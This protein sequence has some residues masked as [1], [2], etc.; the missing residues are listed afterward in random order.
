MTNS[1]N[2]NRLPQQPSLPQLRKQAKEL[3]RACRSG[4]QSAT[5]R[6]SNQLRQLAKEASRVSLSLAQFTLARE[7]GFESWS[8]L[9]FFIESQ[10]MTFEEKL[11]LFVKAA[12]GNKLYISESLLKKEPKLAIHDLST[13]CIV[14]DFAMVERLIKQNPSLVAE[15]VGVESWTPLLYVCFSFF[16]RK[17]K[18]TAENLLKT[19]QVLISAGADVNATYQHP[20]HDQFRIPCLY[21]PSGA[22]NFPELTELLL[23]A[24]ANPDER[25]S[26]Y[27]ST[28]FRDGRC[29][30]LLLQHGASADSWGA[31]HHILDFDDL[32]GA[33]KLLKAGANPNVGYEDLGTSLHHAIVRGRGRKTIELLLEFGAI[34]DRENARGHTPY[35]LALRYGNLEAIEV[36]RDKSAKR[37]LT[38]ASELIACCAA[39]DRKGAEKVLAKNPDLIRSLSEFDR[40]MVAEFAALGKAEAVLLMIDLGFDINE[41]GEWGGPVIQQAAWNGHV[42][43]V[44]R[45]IERSPDLELVNNYGGTALGATVFATEYLQ[46]PDTDTRYIEMAEAL[47]DA[48]AKLLPHLKTTGNEAMAEF[49]RTYE[50]EY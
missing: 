30:N 42:E 44:D 23:K 49:L 2:I 37:M 48:G 22:T 10:G 25:E 5:E 13:A 38:P 4:D 40:R 31:L 32:E 41:R 19:A 43:L 24:G 39:A 36:L 14:G 50:S 6:V 1:Q 34:N 12:V 18:E 15:K 35:E 46:I 8:K 20:G 47:L 28:E 45:L 16:N 33:R 27:H 7:Y 29:M 17:S 26:L 9:K 21:G 3:L 11:K